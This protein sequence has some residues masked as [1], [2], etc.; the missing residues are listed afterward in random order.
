MVRWASWAV[1]HEVLPPKSRNM[2][3]VGLL[4]RQLA[5]R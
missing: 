2:I 5:N 1:S 3:T 4:L